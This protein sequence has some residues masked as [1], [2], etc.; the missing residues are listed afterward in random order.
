VAELTKEERR[1]NRK[2]VL[3]ALVAETGSFGGD[4]AAARVKAYR[5]DPIGASTADFSYVGA[6]TL[7]RFYIDGAKP[8]GVERRS[9]W[10]ELTT[11]IGNPGAVDPGGWSGATAVMILQAIVEEA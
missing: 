8:N 7:T 2:H 11:R 9:L 6:L 4:A 1:R 5:K 10:Q 3:D